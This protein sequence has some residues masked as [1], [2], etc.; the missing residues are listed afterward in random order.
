MYTVV[1]N[2]KNDT[3]NKFEKN[4]KWKLKKS[5]IDIK[6]REICNDDDYIYF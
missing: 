4:N 5:I 6:L 2:N 1:F 3:D